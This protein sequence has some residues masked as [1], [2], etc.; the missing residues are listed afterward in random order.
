MTV[1][2]PLIDLE[3]YYGQAAPADKYFRVLGEKTKLDIYLGQSGGSPILRLI[4]PAK[5]SK[6]SE[7]A[8]VAVQESQLDTSSW[9]YTLQLKDRSFYDQFKTLVYELLLLAVKAG[10]AKKALRALENRYHL[11]MEFWKG[12]HKD[13]TEKVLQGLYGEISYIERLLGRKFDPLTV[14]QGW[15][16]PEDSEKDFILPRYWAE[17]KTIRNGKDRVQ[18]SSLDQL[19][20]LDDDERSGRLV[21]Y[22]V[23]QTE[24]PEGE[25]VLHLIKR[26]TKMLSVNPDAVKYFE[27]TVRHFGIRENEPKLETLRFR[28]VDVKEYSATDSD[29]PSITRAKASPAVASATYSLYLGLLDTWLIKD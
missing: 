1:S 16:G 7:S 9:T 24:A 17:I 12:T 5:A 29:F 26:V 2:E 21:V 6:F 13:L 18:I 23:D 15:T 27:S 19:Q 3:K 8:A 22:T 11:W 14:V 10:D 20:L 25:S 28:C 4:A